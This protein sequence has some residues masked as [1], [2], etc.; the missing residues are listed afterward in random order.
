MVKVNARPFPSASP[1]KTPV[2][3]RILV[4][5]DLAPGVDGAPLAVDKNSLGT[6]LSNLAPRVSARVPERLGGGAR[7]LACELTFASLKAFTPDAVAA[8]IPVLADLLRARG[9][10]E[11]ALRGDVTPADLAA[12]LP[13][14]FRDHELGA[15]VAAVHSQRPPQ[16]IPSAAAAV[17]PQVAA[18]DA[19]LAQVELPATAATPFSA[20]SLIDVLTSALLPAVG[21]SAADRATW[22]NVLAEIDARL[23]RQT[24]A[25]LEVTAVRELE[26]AWR[27]LKFLV[28][29]IDFRK[30]ISL[31]ILPT[32]R[33]DLLDNF[34]NK[35]FKPEYEGQ[36]EH[37]L[38]LVVAD[39][40]FD[41]GVADLETLQHAARMA[42][43]LRVPFVAS[44]AP[45]YFGVRQAALL[46]TLPDLV[47]KC[48][49]PEYAK[50]N[51]L[52][53]QDAS[54]WLALT[55]NR[56]LLR[57][58]WGGEGARPQAFTWDARSGDSA[59]QPL[60]GS[61]V[62]GLAAAVAQSFVAE[63]ASFPVTGAQPPALLENL[64]LRRYRAG[65]AEAVLFPLE[66]MLGE[67]RA[68]ELI[69]CGFMPL[70]AQ[71]GRDAA[72]FA[73][74]PTFFAPP[75]YDQ[76][77]ATRASFLAATLPY[78]LFAGLAGARVQR[79]GRELRGG[80][81]ADQIAAEFSRQL[82][83]FLGEFEEHP[84]G[85]EA[86]VEATPAPDAPEKL[87]VMVRLRPQWKI[88][89]GSVDLILGT[90]VAGG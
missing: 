64:S 6:V 82:A 76:E 52:R 21:T 42:E 81:T 13:A 88:C 25:C 2:G 68:W 44:V 46:A 49:S 37:P 24:S 47:G 19:L 58:A 59:D 3:L 45:Q 78:Q 73:G 30:S 84:E 31:E 23:T 53:T 70:V 34:Y 16:A 14:A 57:D 74:A 65:K 35:V 48:H 75:R 50:W 9:L 83:A 38:S 7:E 80:M 11:A 90:Q 18:L 86:Q 67:Q 43:S 26:S 55:A 15:R 51:R 62:W 61:G 4:L 77:E 22:R 28:D 29:R 20:A 27:G 33:A 32:S 66:V 56:L 1:E 60:W 85:T 8:A 39:F 10:I 63:G 12:R 5:A 89:G 87:D 69:Q 71:A 17:G 79:I 72:Y 54:L 41:R 40:A 36:T